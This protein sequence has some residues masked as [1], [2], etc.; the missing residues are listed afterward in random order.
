VLEAN[1]LAASLDKKN[2]I[3]ILHVD[4]DSS[5]REISKQILLEMGNFEIDNACCVDEAFKKLSTGHYD[6]VVSDYEMHQKNG[7]EFLKELRG[8]KNEIPFILFTGKGRE[9]VAI[10]ALNLGADGYHNKQGE[11]ETVYGELAHII[12]SSF[13]RRNAQKMFSESEERFKKLVTN[14]KDAI[15]LTQEDGIILYLSPACK[16]VL[17]YEPNELIGKVPWIIHPD[18]LEKVQKVFQSALTSEVS[19]TLEY[20]ILTKQGETK[21][22]NHA[23][24]QIW[25]NDKLKQIV[26]NLTD[27][28]ERKKGE[29]VV[30]KSEARYRELANFLP[31]IVFETDLS[32]KITFFSQTAFELTGYT[33]EELEKG[34]NMLQFVVAED[35]ERAKENIRKRLAGEKTA[36][37]E[38]TL[39]RKNGDTYPAIVKTAPIFSDNKLRGL[40]GLVIDITERREAEEL[41]RESEKK[42][43]TLIEQSTQGLLLGQG[44]TPHIVFANSTMAK[45]MGYSV[46]E[47]SSLS[48]QQVLGLVHPDDREFFFER[49]KK[50]LEGKPTPAQYEFRGIKKDGSTVWLELSST[51]IEYQ[52]QPTLQAVFADISERKKAEEELSKSEARYRDLADSLPEIVFETDAL[53]KLTYANQ[54]AFKITGYTKEDLAKGLSAFDLVE[55]KDKEKAKEHLRKT[56]TNNPF[57]DNEYTFVRKDGTIFP[58]MIVSKPI[59]AENKPVGLRGIVI[60]ITYRKKNEE[61]T[62]R[63]TIAAQSERD[64]LSSLINSISDEVWFADTN[65]KFTLANP[66]ALTTFNLDSSAPVDVE[67]LAKSLEV[68]RADGSPRPVDE[69]PP[70][71][72]LKGK[73]VKDQEEIVRIPAS[74]ELQYRQV[75]STPV[76]DTIGNIIGAVSIVRDVTEYKKAER[77]LKEQA[78]LIDLSP[79]AIIVKKPDET[80]TFWN[81]GAEKL[82]GYTKQEAIGQKINI[83]LKAKY[84]RSSDEII[85]Q[86][87]Q[88]KSWTSEITNYTKNNNKVIVQSHWTATLNSQGD[89]EEILESN[90]DITERKKAE[91]VVQKSE[92]K[93]RELANFL[94]EIV[95]ETDLRGKITF[96]SQRALEVAG[97][98]REE[99]EKGLNLLSFVVPEERERAMDNM[100]KSLAGVEHGANEYT[101]LR[102]NGTTYPAIVRTNPIISENKVTGLRGIAL[103]ITERK[104]TEKALQESETRFRMYMENSP[105]AVFVANPEGR[106]EYVNEAACK[107]L[108]YSKEELLEMSIRQVAFKQDNQK[109]MSRFVEVKET[110]RSL[111]EI[112]LKT[113]DGLP[114]YVILNSVKLPDGKLMAFC[115][116]ITERK[117]VGEALEES[118]RRLKA[119]VANSPIGIA[120][121]GADKQFLSANEAFCKI[122]GYTEEELRKLTFKDI[123]HPAD[124]K[125]SAL[126]ME[127]LENGKISSFTLEKRYIKKDGSVVDGKVMVSKVSNQNGKPALFVAE[128]EDITE[129][130]KTE[131]QR[132]VLEK[133]VNDYSKYLKYMVDLRTTQLKDSNERLVKAER[134]AAIGELA[135]MVGHDLRN[136]LAGIKN[137]VYFLKKKG[138]TI[139]EEQSKEMLEVIDKAIEH[140]D[141]IINDLLEYARDMHLELADSTLPTLLD[142]ALRMIQVPDRIQI[143]NHVNEGIL[144]NVDADK[145]MRI[146][147]NL[148]KNAIDAIPE[149][150]TIEISSCKIRDC[151]EIAFSDTGTGLPK[152][153]L[154]KIFTPLFTTKAQGMGF[155]LAICKRIIEAHGGT[156][157][158]KT[159]LNKGTTFTISLPT[160]P[161]VSSAENQTV[162]VKQN[163]K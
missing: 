106:Y 91:E 70:L 110:G 132:R 94:P 84:F 2:I 142:A 87:K 101:L 75:N 158:V 51:L 150:G 85:A 32:G 65:G 147:M 135:G 43:R 113:K 92:A 151:I 126:K 37:S 49:F 54:N 64:R 3:H 39:F 89:I 4:D 108:G 42:Y 24:S 66:K 83:L 6:V 55:Q 33:P 12:V 35:R 7:L 23:F 99:L 56:L 80:I 159:A 59:L 95:F 69:A 161:K 129:R 118:E 63:L 79:D 143:L 5:I 100:K 98:T 8:A 47:L 60:D 105:V 117:Q 31:E 115:E 73:I 112:A 86:L 163:A 111:S 148:I 17:G 121:S 26:S 88:G 68:F 157:S 140:S 50:R 62:R 124:F 102:K 144:I 76:K 11:P 30:K 34:M 153:T 22:I 19:E 97:F 122:L 136:P 41:L 93:Y 48:L 162:T 40:R 154:S 119:V 156:I 28:T 25:E 9:E 74:G 57:S 107:L 27:I 152:E 109:D 16:N 15:M 96:F 130:K 14:S 21:W 29:E 78:A 134:L 82:Y 137:A 10:K 114:V 20:R 13:E 138:T 155:G 1:D 139:K 149:K 120:T 141:K 125:E 90:M 145:I 104:K 160:K 146:F 67:Q 18:D 45:I 133:K 103:D 116:N 58:V 81:K 77:I 61:E 128:L 71:R 53:G 38:Y 72:A 131:D 44:P 127:Q 36:S 123:T 46:Q 52:G